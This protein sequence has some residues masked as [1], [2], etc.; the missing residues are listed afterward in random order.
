M[1][2]TT[3]RALYRVG[4]AMAVAGGLACFVG[5]ALHPR[6]T[7]YYGDPV[8]WMNHNTNSSIWFLAH[9]LILVGVIL[10]TGAYVAL[11]NSLEGT[12]GAGIGRLAQANALIGTALIV[13]TLAIDGLAVPKL[14]QAWNTAQPPS[15]DAVLAGSFIYHSIF[16]LLYTLMLVLFGIAP[17][18]F[19]VAMRFSGAYSRRLSL[20]G[21]VVGA[22]VVI[23]AL[24]SMYGIAT[25]FLDA[26][27][28]SVQ[29]GVIVL[30]YLPIGVLLWRRATVSAAGPDLP[31]PTGQ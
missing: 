28:W 5:N 19:G 14:A 27:V 26:I 2:L 20:I 15:P 29:A 4:G 8:A 12:P 30:W 10:L 16:S 6:S 7:T 31:R 21:V 25:E 18:L 23:T 22:T 3:D 1:N 11:S 17:I 24:L 9:V 13:V